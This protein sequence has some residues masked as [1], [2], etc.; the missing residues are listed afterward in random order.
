[1]QC[2]FIRNVS[3]QQLI[4][5]ANTAQLYRIDFLLDSYRCLQIQFWQ[6]LL[7]ITQSNDHYLPINGLTIIMI[8]APIHDISGSFRLM[9]RFA[10]SNGIHFWYGLIFCQMI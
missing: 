1:M 10:I 9:T 8:V 6:V 4:P 2:F 5:Q 7:Y 3:F